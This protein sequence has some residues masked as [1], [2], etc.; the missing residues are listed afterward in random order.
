[1]SEPT[2]R[3]RWRRWAVVLGGLAV[4]LVATLVPTARWATRSSSACTGSCH[5]AAAHLATPGHDGLSCQSCHAVRGG[6]AL[7]LSV[8][9]LLGS[10][11][12]PEHGALTAATC[13]GCHDARDARWVNVAQTQG[14]RKHAGVDDVDCL[15]CHAKAMHGQ[16]AAGA[17]CLGCHDDARLH[18]VD[19]FDEGPEPRCLSCHNFAAPPRDQV[20]HAGLTVEACARCHGPGATAG[21]GVTPGQVVRP[22]DLH[23]S[24]DCKQCHQPHSTLPMQRPCR[25]CH[26]VQLL[27]GRPNLPPEHLECTECHVQHQPLAQAGAECAGCHEEA[28]ARRGGETAQS[29][30]LRHDECASCHLPHTWA[31]AP[32]DCITCHTKEAGL[33]ATKSPERHQRCIDCHE[34]RGAPPSAATCAPCHKE[35]ARKANVS[36]APAKHR[37]C[38]G[39]HDPHAPKGQVPQTCAECH[40]EALHQVVT[41]GPADHVK[42]KCDG[43]HAVHGDPR[44]TTKGC[45]SCHKK[46]GAQVAK[47]TALPKHQ[48]CAG[49]HLAHTFDFQPKTPSCSVTCHQ[50]IT[51]TSGTHEGDCTK[52]H[53]AHAAPTVARDKCLGC[54]DEIVLKVPPKAPEHAKC[55]SCHTPHTPALEARAKCTEGCHEDKPK[56]AAV[57]PARSAHRDNCHECHASHDVKAPVNCL[58]CHKKE[59]AAATGGK[60]EC[61]DCHAP[62]QPPVLDRKGWWNWC[63]GCHQKEVAASKGHSDC[64]S[65]HKPHAFGPPTCASCHADEVEKGQH[66][67]KEHQECTKCHDAHQAN[68]P[69]RAQCLACHEGLQDHEPRAPVCYGC[70]TFMK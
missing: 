31:A 58:E 47:V 4:V 6:V 37:D 69:T 63:E 29:T 45:A 16:Q 28:K 68:P 22:E 8:R 20:A 52:C 34:V 59:A 3:S 19:V 48:E 51:P 30:A 25:S 35:N 53:A 21:P 46:E 32:N 13:A 41:L 67:T 38:A 10:R 44:A 40:Q 55:S 65:C 49:C 33:V 1:M 64:Q 12:G 5:D 60:H 42:A 57:W 17:T 56:V 43:C 14:H 11:G 39:C 70:H 27:S 61:K 24:L 26:Q 66:L 18:P 15:S 9:G 7:R 50:D 2:S 23:G 62:H 36:A 54:H